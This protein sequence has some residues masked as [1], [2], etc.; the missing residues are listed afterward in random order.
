MNFRVSKVI[1][2]VYEEAEQELHDKAGYA[3]FL[4]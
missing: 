3:E 1:I 4:L 2:I